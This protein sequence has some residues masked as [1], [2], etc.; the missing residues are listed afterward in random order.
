M[1]SENHKK[2]VVN[3]IKEHL[4]SMGYTDVE[5]VTILKV[6]EEDENTY[7]VWLCETLI[8][9]FDTDKQEFIN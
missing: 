9:I 1:I 3:Q 8:G 5:L 4:Q 2:K 6:G 7:E